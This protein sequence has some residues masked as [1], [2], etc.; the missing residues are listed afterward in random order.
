AGL[1]RQ[2]LRN[3]GV[4]LL[5]LNEA[6]QPIAEKW[7]AEAMVLSAEYLVPVVVFGG[8]NLSSRALVTGRHE[9]V[10]DLSWLSA[11]QIALTSAIEASPLNQELRRSRD[12]SGV[13]HLGWQPEFDQHVGNYLMLAWS[14]PLPLRRIRDFSARCPDLVVSGVGVDSLTAD[15]AAQGISVAQWRFAVK[16]KL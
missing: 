13:L 11:R 14:S 1:F 10:S 16:Y 4:P 7:L 2:S 9:E 12:K 6:P 15:V 3:L 8:I 5:E